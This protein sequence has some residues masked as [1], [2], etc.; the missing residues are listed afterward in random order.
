M[1]YFQILTSDS[2][3]LKN[4][5]RA[6]QYWEPLNSFAID[7]SKI[8]DSDSIDIVIRFVEA[9]R[10]K[11]VYFTGDPNSEKIEMPLLLYDDD[12]FKDLFFLIDNGTVLS[13]KS[14]IAA[15]SPKFYEMLDPQEK[16]EGLVTVKDVSFT[17]FKAF[18]KYLYTNQ[19]DDIKEIAK[20]LLTFA[21]K[22]E[23][24][25]LKKKC[26][27]YLSQ[28]LN[29]GNAI[30]LLVKADVSDCPILKK[31]SL[32]MIKPH[33]KRIRQSQEFKELYKHPHL[34][35]EILES[36][37]SDEED[38]FASPSKQTKVEALSQPSSLS[39][40]M[41]SDDALSD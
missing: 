2:N 33:L 21:V 1:S 25:S 19:V 10:R 20:D 14:V 18:V 9:R 24:P 40:V 4:T 13:H 34:M 36:F 8:L 17:T 6:N 41:D 28:T 3:Y 7:K 26:E 23:L 31:R 32:F 15:R 16:K 12:T 29:E 30:N 27:N 11:D 39:P 22:Y 38:E 5:I 35:D 37:C